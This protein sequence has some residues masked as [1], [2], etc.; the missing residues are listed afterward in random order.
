MF[1]LEIAAHF[2]VPALVGLAVVPTGVAPP[3]L[4]SEPVKD[5]HLVVRGFPLE[6]QPLAL[7]VSGPASTPFQILVDVWA[8]GGAIGEALP[9]PGFLPGTRAAVIPDP[10][11]NAFTGPGFTLR[12]VTDA[13]G[14][15][16]KPFQAPRAGTELR[17]IGLAAQQG[18]AERFEALELTILPAYSPEPGDV[19]ITEIL[20][21][22]D[23]L[24]T[25]LG[26]WIEAF[27]QTD[28]DIDLS[29]WT[30]RDD[31]GDL[32]VISNGSL[33]PVVKS[34]SFAILGAER[35]A[36][37]LHQFASFR[38]DPDADEVVLEDASGQTI[39]RVAY[40]VRSGWPASLRGVSLQ[41][42]MDRLDAMANDQPSA[43][44]QSTT[45]GASIGQIT[46][47]TSPARATPCVHNGNPLVDVPDL[48]Y[49]D[50]NCDGIDGDIARAVFVSKTGLPTNPGTMAKPLAD[51]Q[52]AINLAAVDPSRDHV[53]VSEGLYTGLVTLASGV[54]VWGGYSEVNGWKRSNT[55][56]TTF[57]NST[58]LA[59]G[60]V[61]V[62]GS[63]LTGAVTLGSVTVTTGSAPSGKSNYG[64][65]LQQ[66]DD[67]TLEGV[68]VVAGSGSL[69]SQGSS[70]QNGANASDGKSGG[71]ACG[72][73]N[74]CGGA[75]GA[76]ANSGGSGGWG[77]GS[78]HPNGYYGATGAGPS[79]GA[80]GY[81]GGWISAGGAGAAGA[82]GADGSAG[83]PGSNVGLLSGGWWVSNGDGKAGSAA[84]AGSGGGGGGGGSADFFFFSGNGGGGGGGGGAPATPGQGGTAG[85][86]SFALCLSAS[87][88]FLE[89]CTLS[90]G[91]GRNGGTG[92]ASGFYGGLHGA[93]GAG[94]TCCSA[95]YGGNGGPGGDGGVGGHG[96]GGGGGHSYGILIDIQ[97]SMAMVSTAVSTSAAGLGGFSAA[98]PGSYGKNGES[99]AV[100][101]L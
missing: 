88:V 18:T 1:Q 15:W 35:D 93:G 58:A 40:D 17:L 87:D 48:N 8:D 60:M 53:Y 37:V 50:T 95:P 98:G 63:N 22:P 61:G 84:T 29:G 62:L 47:G 80:G 94:A 89:S 7:V 76:G 74:Y 6:G 51:V 90:A 16:Q 101:Q 27:N 21:T 96:A 99:L 34:R 55:Y 36:Q 91:T 24:E 4:T 31:H 9:Q 64:I 49:F 68:K 71:S 59:N 70:G 46:P 44:T 85:S 67:V 75:G 33:D 12:A 32:H 81:G 57:S 65:L 100:K 72:G 54:S 78:S 56:V 66:S 79:G 26:Q 38:L 11:A 69:G 43:W 28:Y 92:G 41:L 5:F 39:D 82:D 19:V 86:S 73:L 20:R 52:V 14:S 3:T 83:Q 10:G 30:L 13:D 2:L 97:S 77:G 45:A 42:L 23:G 25:P